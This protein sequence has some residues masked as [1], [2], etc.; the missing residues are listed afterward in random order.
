MTSFVI[1][2]HSN[3]TYILPSQKG[4]LFN[5]ENQ[6]HVKKKEISWRTTKGRTITN[7]KTTIDCKVES[8]RELRKHER[9]VSFKKIDIFHVLF[10]VHRSNDDDDDHCNYRKMCIFTEIV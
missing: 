1:S 6:F 3:I 10:N 4:H 2:S 9:S 7:N 8:K 5:N